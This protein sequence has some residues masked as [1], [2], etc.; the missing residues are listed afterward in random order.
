M[1][2]YRMDSYVL[3]IMEASCVKMNVVRPFLMAAS[4]TILKNPPEE[5]FLYEEFISSS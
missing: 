1:R 3:K 2:A 5:G 4:C